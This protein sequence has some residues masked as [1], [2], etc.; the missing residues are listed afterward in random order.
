[1]KANKYDANQRVTS[2]VG[3]LLNDQQCSGQLI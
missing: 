2:W 1:M 3:K